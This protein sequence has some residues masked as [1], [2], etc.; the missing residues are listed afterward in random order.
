VL[1]E[2][3]FEAGQGLTQGD[4]KS[5]LSWVAV[6]DILLT[7]MNDLAAQEHLQQCYVRHAGSFLYNNLAWAFADDLVTISPTRETS[8]RLGKFVS[9]ALMVLG[10]KLATDKLR[11][12]SSRKDSRPLVVYDWDWSPL[13][14]DFGDPTVSVKILGLYINL[15]LNWQPAYDLLA[16]RLRQAITI[17]APK[18]GRLSTK[19]KVM[20]LSLQS[21]AMYVAQFAS[22]NSRQLAALDGYFIMLL[23]GYAH[24]G[25][26][27]ANAI[28]L[29]PKLGGYLQPMWEQVTKR[30]HALL[31]R[32][33]FEGGHTRLAIES[34]MM[35]HARQANG[36]GLNDPTRLA[37]PFILSSPSDENWWAAHLVIDGNLKSPRVQWRYDPGPHSPTCPPLPNTLSGPE[38]SFMLTLIYSRWMS[39]SI[40]IITPLHPFLGWLQKKLRPHWWRRYKAELEPLRRIHFVLPEGSYYYSTEMMARTALS[41]SSWGGHMAVVGRSDNGCQV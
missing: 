22:F 8:I 17:Q 21:S 3:G 14:K 16:E 36:Q 35:R 41:F 24:T 40:G 23:R 37:V 38:K 19:L 39:W 32:A 5:T 13:S 28:I 9:T 15:N 30:K 31:Q 10:L 33:T 34:L 12:V 6:F 4:V 18:M 29:E 26:H 2:D 25:G 27:V 11:M 7:A 1:R 20:I